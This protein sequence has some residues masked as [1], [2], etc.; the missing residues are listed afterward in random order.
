MRSP[1]PQKAAENINQKAFE[2]STREF[3]NT[4]KSWESE[5]VQLKPCPC[6]KLYDS[7]SEGEGYSAADGAGG[8][9]QVD[10]LTVLS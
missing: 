10:R 4:A 3:L 2:Q 6:R 9:Y 7:Y 1:S 5:G 8:I